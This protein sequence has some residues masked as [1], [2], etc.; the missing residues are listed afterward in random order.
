MLFP[1]QSIDFPKFVDM[2]AIFVR[3][4]VEVHNR[5]VFS[6]FNISG[7]GNL[8]EHDMFQI[9]QL[10][11]ESESVEPYLDL[12]K[13]SDLPQSVYVA[14]HNNTIFSEAISQD[15]A[16]ITA[17][18]NEKEKSGWQGRC[19][20]QQRLHSDILA[21]IQEQNQKKKVAFD[22]SGA[23]DAS[24][25]VFEHNNTFFENFNESVPK[26]MSLTLPEFRNVKFERGI[27][28]FFDDFLKLVTNN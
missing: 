22:L 5:F 17:Y 16:R 26:C 24:R 4:P 9:L 27:S 2:I 6:A 10:L 1:G 8:C 14:D 12:L 3:S 28:T 15:F 23:G 20:G 21:R 13:E 18:F 11:K 7:S 25:N 19:S